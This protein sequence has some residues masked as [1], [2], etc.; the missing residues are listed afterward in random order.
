MS[1]LTVGKGEDAFYGTVIS[2]A[3]FGKVMGYIA[4]GKEEAKLEIGGT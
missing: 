1:E 3:Q 4:K 2:Q